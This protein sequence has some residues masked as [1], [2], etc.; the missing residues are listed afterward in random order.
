[1]PPSSLHARVHTHTHAHLATTTEKLSTEESVTAVLLQMAHHH[2]T[3]L[4]PWQGGLS[5]RQQT[6]LFP[7]TR[8]AHSWGQ[9]ELSGGGAKMRDN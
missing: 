6:D 3:F 7:N 9:S 5:R 4:A 1:M 2:K 8:E